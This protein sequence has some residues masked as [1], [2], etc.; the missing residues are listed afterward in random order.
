MNT[1]K[2]GSI[3]INTELDIPD[4]LFPFLRVLENKIL[5]LESSETFPLGTKLSY[6]ANGNSYSFSKV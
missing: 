4:F 1:E 3:I 6:E 2:T 5:I